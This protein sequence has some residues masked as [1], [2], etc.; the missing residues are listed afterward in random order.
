MG[1]VIQ[2]GT[3]QPCA[4]CHKRPATLLCDM[5]IG[6]V[7]NMHVKTAA[8]ETDIEKSFKEHTITCDKAVC[9]KCAKEISKD[10]HFCKK[11]LDKVK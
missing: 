1:K 5:P 6:R 10:I 9:D 2:A 4:I 11:C 8:G 3:L 7:K